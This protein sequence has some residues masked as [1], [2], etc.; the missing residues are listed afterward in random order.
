MVAIPAN[1][2]ELAALNASLQAG[3]ISYAT[4]YHNLEQ[5]QLTRP[6]V[7]AEEEQETIDGDTEN[8][9]QQRAQ[10]GRLPDNAEEIDE[11]VANIGAA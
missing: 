1:P 8:I 5:L 4:Y 2:Q 3:V 11:K 7:D 9:F 6:G 10:G